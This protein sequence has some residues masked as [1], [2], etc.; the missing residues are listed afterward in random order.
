MKY[1]DRLGQNIGESLPEAKRNL[2]A[3]AV[4]NP[5][6]KETIFRPDGM[7][8]LSFIWSRRH[9]STVNR[10]PWFN[11]PIIQKDNKQ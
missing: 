11:S 7:P 9:G 10:G 8:V 1:T 2:L 5:G 6:K 3:L 4:P